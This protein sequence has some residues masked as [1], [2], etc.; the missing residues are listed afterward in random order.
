VDTNT[1]NDRTVEPVPDRL[2]LALKGISGVIKEETENEA[3]T[4]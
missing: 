4:G 3:D 2:G 1:P